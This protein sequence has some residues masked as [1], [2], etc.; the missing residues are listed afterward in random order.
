[1]NFIEYVK[2]LWKNGPNGGTPWSASRLNHMEEGIK[3]NNEMISELNSNLS[4]VSYVSNLINVNNE[5]CEIA[6][7][8]YGGWNAS[9]FIMIGAESIYLVEYGHDVNGKTYLTRCNAVKVFGRDKIIGFKAINNVLH[10][11]IKQT[12]NAY[13]SI[14]CLGLRTENYPLVQFNYKV[15]D[16]TA[17]DMDKIC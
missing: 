5:W 3:A 4:N 2:Q 6:T 13:S 15:T 17:D 16:L 14:A 1:M 8:S 9:R 12:N 7:Y 10:I 11:Y